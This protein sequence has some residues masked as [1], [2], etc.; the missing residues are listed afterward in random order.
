MPVAEAILDYLNEKR[1]GG[2]EG[3]RKERNGR[4]YEVGPKGGYELRNDNPRNPSMF[5]ITMI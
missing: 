1:R 4:L 2:R 5:T 3:E